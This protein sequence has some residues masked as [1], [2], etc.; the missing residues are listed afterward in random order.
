MAKIVVLAAGQ[1]AD[2]AKTALEGAGLDFDVVDP[3][4]SNLLHIVI[5]MVDE[6]PAE[7]KEPKEPKAP[8][9]PKEPKEEPVEEPPID[10]PPPEEVPE[11][12]GKVFVEGE[13]IYAFKSSDAQSVV[14]AKSVTLGPK[15]TYALAEGT[16][17]FWPANAEVP[18]QR[19]TVE[20]NKH[21]TS[22]ELPIRQSTKGSSYLSVGAD[23]AD[24]FKIK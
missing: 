16:F 14:F 4:A 6:E 13:E 8:K 9:E 17:S 3:T 10:E 22:V 15:T 11:S 21:K 2:A 20:L 7:P 24:L 18:A 1:D 12:L 5:G 19:L 23:L